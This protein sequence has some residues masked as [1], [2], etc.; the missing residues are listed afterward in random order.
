[1]CHDLANVEPPLAARARGFGLCPGPGGADTMGS[2]TPSC[3]LEKGERVWRQMRSLEKG[4]K[5]WGKSAEFVGMCGARLLDSA[6]RAGC[7]YGRGLGIVRL[8]LREGMCCRR[9]LATR[10][11]GYELNMGITHT[12]A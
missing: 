3:N 12:E 6:W 7:T 9:G 5:T 2:T 11:V 1:M 4:A 10:G 8:G